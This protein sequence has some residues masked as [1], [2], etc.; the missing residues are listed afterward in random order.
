MGCRRAL[1]IHQT[2]YAVCRLCSPPPTSSPPHSPSLPFFANNI[3]CKGTRPLAES[4]KHNTTVTSQ[5]LYC[6]SDLN[7]AKQW[8]A[9][10]QCQT[11]KLPMFLGSWLIPPPPPPTH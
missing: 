6:M 10:A 5:N 4:L 9:A 7:F 8:V 3:G 11:I 2:P 1:R